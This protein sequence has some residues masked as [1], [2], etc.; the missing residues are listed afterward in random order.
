M[1][2]TEELYQIANELRAVASGGLLWTDSH[3]DRERYMQVLNASAKLIATIEKRSPTEILA[4]FQDNLFHSSP[5]A[6]V[7]VVIVQDGKILLIQRSDDKLWALPGGLAEIG[8]TLAEAAQRELWEETGIRG[9]I[10]RMLGVFDSHQWKTRTKVQLYSVIFQAEISSGVLTTSLETS[11]L[12]FFEES[13]LPP[14][15]QGH[16]LR[17]PFVFKILHGQ[18][19]IPYF[20]VTSTK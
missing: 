15:S 5:L 9:K 17:I 16:H 11:A 1:S 4:H 19:P 2:S 12:A 3:Y 13:N 8:E 10:T 7:E 20:D 6:G 14:L 18:V